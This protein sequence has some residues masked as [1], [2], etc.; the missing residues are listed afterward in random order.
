MVKI[1]MGLNGSGKT[2]KLV[3]MVRDSLNN[4]AGDVI[5]VENENKLTYDI[6]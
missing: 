3:D 5:V 6:P 1:I 2:R 4:G